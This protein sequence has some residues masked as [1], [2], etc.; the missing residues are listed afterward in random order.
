MEHCACSSCWSVR[1]TQCWQTRARWCSDAASC[2][3]SSHPLATFHSINTTTFTMTSNIA[4]LSTLSNK[5]LL[6]QLL[7][8]PVSDGDVQK[9]FHKAL[10][11]WHP[12]KCPDPQRVDEHVSIY[13][14]LSAR[15]KPI[16]ARTTT[17]TVGPEFNCTSYP[18]W[19]TR[20]A[21][22]SLK[23]RVLS[24]RQWA[25]QLKD[26]ELVALLPC[27]MTGRARAKLEWARKY[28]KPKRKTG[29]SRDQCLLAIDHA[30]L[31][32][33]CLMRLNRIGLRGRDKQR[34][35]KEEEL[36]T[37]QL[38]VAPPVITSSVILG[39][40]EQTERSAALN[41]LARY[42]IDSTGV[43][44]GYQNEAMLVLGAV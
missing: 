26:S 43:V 2:H 23:E 35:V 40:I 34:S 20:V 13:D 12:R 10:L 7:G 37:E 8:E 31:Y 41:V 14:L 36:A 15:I 29:D 39:Y 24:L 4:A 3:P 25:F 19:S 22:L 30:E 11:L 38:S 28:Y 9:C 17:T 44:V 21:H 18:A 33:I 6:S 5:Q 32:K 1:N 42:N 27:T 16:L